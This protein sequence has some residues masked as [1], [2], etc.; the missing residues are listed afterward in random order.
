MMSRKFVKPGDIFERLTVISLISI[1]NRTRCWLCLCKCGIYCTAITADLN[2]K[3]KRSCGCLQREHTRSMGENITVHGE[4]RR[5]GITPEIRCWNLMKRR[6]YNKNDQSYER[7][8][9]RGRTV[10]ERWLDK[11]NGSRNF[12]ADMGPKPE[13]KNM[14]SIDRKNNNGNYEPNNCRWA[15]RLEQRANQGP[16]KT[17]K[18]FRAHNKSLNATR[19]SNSKRGFAREYGL[20]HTGICSCLNKGKP[21]HKGW[22]FKCLEK[23]TDE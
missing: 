5:S 20:Q 21:V 18:W 23:E 2:R 11:E 10:C 12:L 9:A 22:T 17:Q 1:I 13:P 14:Y 16:R 8:G 19:Y 4:S 6:C 3:H 15:T 7:Y